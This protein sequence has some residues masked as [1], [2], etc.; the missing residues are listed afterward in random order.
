MILAFYNSGFYKLFLVL[1]LLSVVIGFGGITITG[2]VGAAS[3]GY[4]GPAGQAIF[5]TSE[6]IG[7]IVE[8][9]IYAVPVFGIALLFI[10]TTGGHHVFW[11]DQTWVTLSLVIYIFTLG[12]VHALHLPNL[13]RMGELMAE[14]NAGPP[15]PAVRLRRRP[16]SKSEASGPAYTAP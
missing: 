1:H 14:I 6:R 7:R 5:D 16:S 12:F 10:S 2:F 8:F 15:P 4:K 9:F 11:F 13:R 3:Q